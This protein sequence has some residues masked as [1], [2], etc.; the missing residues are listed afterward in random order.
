[1]PTLDEIVA[2]QNTS[3]H[4]LRQSLE[5]VPS[6]GGGVDKDFKVDEPVSLLDA[7]ADQ[8]VT[9]DGENL[10][11]WAGIRVWLYNFA[12]GVETGGSGSTGSDDPQFIGICKCPAPHIARSREYTDSEE[13][14]RH[15]VDQTFGTYGPLNGADPV[16]FGV[17]TNAFN[18]DSSEAWEGIIKALGGDLTSALDLALSVGGTALPGLS[19]FATPGAVGRSI[20]D[21]VTDAL[22]DEPEPVS[23]DIVLVD[24]VRAV[25]WYRKVAQSSWLARKWLIYSLPGKPAWYLTQWFI[26]LSTEIRQYDYAAAFRSDTAQE[27]AL[28]MARVDDGARDLAAL[29]VMRGEKVEAVAEAS[30]LTPAVIHSSVAALRSLDDATFSGR[31]LAAMMR[32]DLPLG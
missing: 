27:F 3:F 13:R 7:V 29:R 11:K 17:V 4:S 9:V 18:N 14:T 8:P 25:H 26:E 30:G 2:N 22:T 21:M 15:D 28:A 5:W 1:M 19:A 10:G 16:R 24:T 12:I 23:D 31:V 6:A 20:V 32:K